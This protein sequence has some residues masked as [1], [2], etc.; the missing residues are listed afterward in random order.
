MR[1]ITQ[2]EYEENVYNKVKDEY[3]VVGIYKNTRTK[4]EMKHNKCGNI[5]PVTPH[6]F[7]SGRRC[8]KCN[9]KKNKNTKKFGFVLK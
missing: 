3:G 7:L 5:Y 2:L 4:I 8:P 9:P 6:D 1:K